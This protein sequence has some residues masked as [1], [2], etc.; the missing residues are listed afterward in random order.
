MQLPDN[1]FEQRAIETARR[2]LDDIHWC[3]AADY[4]VRWLAGPFGRAPTLILAFHLPETCHQPALAIGLASVS[5]STG[6]LAVMEGDRLRA[7]VR[8]AVEDY[9]TRCGVVLTPPLAPLVPA[10][11]N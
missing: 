9:L 5:R 6:S 1:D 4:S 11:A 2:H 8:R 3:A 7:H 10:L